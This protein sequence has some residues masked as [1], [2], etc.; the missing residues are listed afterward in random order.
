MT[1]QPLSALPSIEAWLAAEPRAEYASEAPFAEVMIDAITLADPRPYTYKVPE[2][3]RGRLLPGMAVLVPFG[4]KRGVAG[5]VTALCDTPPEDHALREIEEVVSG[6]VMPPA[7][8]RLFMWMA[9][10]TMAPL[11]AVLGTA[12][13]R[14]TLARVKRSVHLAVSQETFE[15]LARSFHGPAA[16]IARVLLTAGGAC[17]LTRLQTAAR[18]SSR[19]LSEWRARGLIRYHAT[20]EC[21]EQREKVQLHAIATPGAFEPLSERQAE[22]VAYLQRAGGVMGLAELARAMGTSAGTLRTVARKGAIAIRPM[23]VRRSAV[24]RASGE[25]PPALTRTQASVLETIAEGPGVD[26]LLGVTGSGKTEVYLRAIAEALARGQ[27][28]IVLVPEIALTP[29]TVRRF[30]GRFG[31]LVAVLHSHLGDGERFDEWQR[32]R[33]GSARV[34]VGA[35]SAVFAPV[36]DLGLIVID[37]EHESSYKQDKSPR[38]HARTVALARARLEG[39]TVILGSAT[40]SLESYTAAL[41]GRY[42]LLEMPERVAE[43]P[44]PPV[45]VVDMRVELEAGNRSL[46]SRALGGALE[47]AI[48]RGEQAILLLNRRGYS[49]FVFCRQCG[50][51]CRCTRCAVALTYHAN[52]T[53]LRCHYC[54]QR[55]EMPETCPECK[56]PYIRHF[57]AGTQ[58][59]EEATA[60]LLPNAR[61]VRV[62]RDTT[63]R[64]GSHQELL[65]AFGRG[66]YDV[67]IGTQMV[68]KGLDFPRVTLVGVMAADGAL[69]LPDFRASERTFQLLTQVAGRAGRGDLESRVVIQTYSPTHPAIVAS[70]AH[71][72]KAF[73]EQEAVDR[74]ETLYPPFVGLV[75]V[76]FAG[77]DLSMTM[78]AAE[79]FAGGLQHEKTWQVFGPVQAPLAM[80]RGLHRM[81]VILK[82][83]EWQGVRATLRQALGPAQRPGVRSAVDIDPQS[84][85]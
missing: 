67:L 43:R 51:V 15:G 72:F 4:P 16:A 79:Q 14:G 26:L 76:L 23:P 46:F 21:Q 57:G 74:R 54:D 73:Y 33:D 52:P 48:A 71:D 36:S 20:L 22:I 47:A 83:P 70:R 35:R 41:E 84:M 9:E 12:M 24:G 39:A 30:Q 62:D 80:L 7:L 28:A 60:K 3:W 38:Y 65:D 32:I 69:H 68:A 25:T 66:D 45:E 78:R 42:K 61:L 19:V 40:P 85:L 27:G 34:V 77:A 6:D 55:Q 17:S 1:V 59:I 10:E 37:E 56:G 31:D 2:P 81:M 11:S 13:P 29:Q 64:K 63:T 75:S 44:L 8:R 49:S 53:H 5:Y 50:Y 58:Q 82:V 18:Q